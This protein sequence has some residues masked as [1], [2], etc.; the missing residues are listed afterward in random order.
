MATIEKPAVNLKE[1]HK[2]N[3]PNWHAM[4]QSWNRERETDPED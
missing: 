2:C 4:G 3:D 1:F